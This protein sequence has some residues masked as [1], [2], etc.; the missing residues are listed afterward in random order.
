MV[1]TIFLIVSIITTIS[2]QISYAQLSSNTNVQNIL[3]N[4]DTNGE[5]QFNGVEACFAPVTVILDTLPAMTFSTL[6]NDGY[7]F[8][9]HGSATGADVALGV[10]SAATSIG[11]VYIIAGWFEDSIT[12]D[13][14][15]LNG[16]GAETSG[17]VACFDAATSNLLWADAATAGAGTYDLA[18]GSAIIGDKA[19][20]VGYFEG[21]TQ[22]GSAS[23]TSAGSYQ[24]FIAKY[25]IP[26][27]NIDTIIQVGNAGS[28]EISNIRAGA[29]DR[30]YVTGDFT[31]SITLAGNSFTANGGID[32]FVTC[33]D[34]S[35]T[36]NYW[37]ATGGGSGTDVLQDVVP[38]SNGAATEY[39]YVT[40]YFAATAT[41]GG[42]SV[43]SAGNRDFVV[44][45]VDTN[46][47][48]IWSESGGSSAVDQSYAIDINSDGDR[49]YVAGQ[50][51]GTMTIGS[52]TY[53]SNGNRDG[54]I[55]YFDTTGAIDDLYQFGST[56]FDGVYDL[57]SIDDDYLIFAAGHVGN[58]DFADST[59]ISNGGLD[60]FAGKIGPDQHEIWG[61]NFGGAGANGDVFNSISAGPDTRMHCAGVIG[62]YASAYQS[63]LVAVGASDA[64]VTNESFKGT[65]DTN[66]V[67][68]GLSAGE[69]YITMTD[70]NGNTVIDTITIIDPDPL[71][72]NGAVTNASSGTSN[73]G[74]I[75]LTI[76]GGTPGYSYS[77]SNTATTEDLTGLGIGTYTVTVT[78]TN[79]CVDTASFVID[80]G[81]VIFNVTYAITDLNCGG[82][83]SGI[84]DLTVS[85]GAT[86]YSFSWNTG[87]TTED[88]SGLAGGTY[89]VTVTDNDTNSFTETFV[90]NEPSEISLSST[91]TPPTNGTTND[92]A[93]DI[94]VSGGSMPYSYSW[95]N[96]A[97]T[98]D[99]SGL[100]IGNYTVT[101]TDSTG[102]TLIESF[103][104]DT[105]PALDA[106]LQSGDVTCLNSNNGAID[107]TLIGGVTPFT[108]AWSNGATTEDI[109]GLAAGVYTV[110][111]TDNLLQSVIAS[112]TVGSN[113][114]FPDPLVGPINGPTSAQSWIAYSYDVPAT[115]GSS[116]DWGATGGI[117][118]STTSNS[119]F[120]QWNAGPDGVI[121]VSE[122]DA[123]GCFGSDSLTVEILF[124]GIEE[125]HQNAI[126]VYPNPAVHVLNV[127]LPES[128]QDVK[129]SLYD[130]AG[131]QVLSQEHSTNKVALDLNGA[132]SGIYIL[133]LQKGET[134][135]THRIV[136]E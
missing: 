103:F 102:C 119:A 62:T 66:L 113:P 95:S 64:I 68:S 100:S 65:A 89:T 75:D 81:S 110:T 69:Y 8:I 122:T 74:E 55:A 57:V 112:D 117:I 21:T 124:V 134:V 4:G 96:A 53:A 120:V 132:T 16:N 84:I 78:D 94:T 33:F 48:W 22:F 72:T 3:C 15:T 123:N 35:L 52:S 76:T 9:N 41:L 79:G 17:F 37:G 131:R 133:H 7:N 114:I 73:D 129:I 109:S 85:G 97:S 40:G 50:W 125:N 49:L 135:L 130:I 128:F 87:A 136:I 126:L 32:L 30:L 1:R 18:Y 90:V 127:V 104:V 39:A 28:D 5:I 27:G 63:G 23:I 10:S 118:T 98:E 59:F 24:G 82:D 19:Y 51:E 29:D 88:L 13:S 121:Y 47:N 70:S 115:S 67:L 11:D 42:T 38:Y 58:I 12:F 111:V 108:F 80:T 54:F 56:G 77:W 14:V 86:P 93:I 25:D 116:F 46:G 45:K 36:T 61:K 92:G 105:I 106:V 91:I 99:I 43:T 31:Q 6:K 71:S 2:V 34:S 60:A 20:V 83:S 101:V 26:T 107:L 44:A